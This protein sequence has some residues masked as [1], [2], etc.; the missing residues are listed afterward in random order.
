[1]K[2]IIDNIRKEERQG[3]KDGIENIWRRIKVS[4]RD[5]R[6]FWIYRKFILLQKKYYLINQE[7]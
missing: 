4:F 7:L 2:K 5:D 6:A 3:F 1:M